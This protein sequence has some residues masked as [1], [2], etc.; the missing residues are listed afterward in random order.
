MSGAAYTVSLPEL[1]AEHRMGIDVLTNIVFRL[2]LPL[3]RR[4]K[5]PAHPGQRVRCLREADA[6]RIRQHLAEQYAHHDTVT[7]WLTTR[8]AASALGITVT[9][10]YQRRDAGH[11]T[12]RRV[13]V[14]GHTGS[15][16][17]TRYDPADVQREAARLGIRPRTP[18]RGT[19]S[20][21]Q[22]TTITGVSRRVIALWV[23]RGC[24][25]SQTPDRK[26]HLHPDRLLA[27][28]EA[29]DWTPKRLNRARQHATRATSNLRAHLSQANAAD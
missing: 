26:L 27:W 7:H 4:A 12:V 5:H 21:T 13:E 9:A 20:T 15:S 6:A 10:F 28:L 18:P 24:P 19:L 1:A 2:K 25:A 22:L 17:A 11:V 29:Q 8:Q 3:Q 23:R 16:R 14:Y